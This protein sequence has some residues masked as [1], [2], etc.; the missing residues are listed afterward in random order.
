MLQRSIITPRINLGA[1]QNSQE[2]YIDHLTK[3]CLR[4]ILQSFTKVHFFISLDL[5]KSSL[6]VYAFE[7]ALHSKLRRDGRMRLPSVAR[8][9][10]CGWVLVILE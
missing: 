3:C 8:S 10:L 7:Q 4:L 9:C 5:N 2:L 6:F 1:A